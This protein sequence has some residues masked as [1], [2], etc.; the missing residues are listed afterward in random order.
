MNVL[1]SNKPEIFS[2]E[3]LTV[4]LN[5]KE[6]TES[7]DF[8]IESSA[9]MK[10]FESFLLKIDSKLNSLCELDKD[11][12]LSLKVLARLLFYILF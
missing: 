8:F 9:E 7:D 5:A 2:K 3:F 6:Q 11:N 10:I 1:S 4:F 12:F